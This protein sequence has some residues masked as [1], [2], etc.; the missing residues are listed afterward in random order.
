MKTEFG[1][2]EEQKEEQKSALF[3]QQIVL[4]MQRTVPVL[5]K[6]AHGRMP[7]SGSFG[8]NWPSCANN[9]K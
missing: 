6:T 3:M 4:S 7:R 8:R 2:K 9:R 1:Q 5:R